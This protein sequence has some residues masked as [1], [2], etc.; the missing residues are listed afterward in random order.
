MVFPIVLIGLGMLLISGGFWGSARLR[1]PYD[2]IIAWGTP[3]GLLVT[4]M[5]V[6]LLIIP[7]FFG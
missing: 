4:L 6:I 5:G 3:L 7:D 2:A 1:S